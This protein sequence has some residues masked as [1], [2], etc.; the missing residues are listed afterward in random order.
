MVVN[1]YGRAPTLK[2]ERMIYDLWQW[3]SSGWKQQMWRGMSSCHK[4][5][6]S[7][8]VNQE[9]SS[10]METLCFPWSGGRLFKYYQINFMFQIIPGL[11]YLVTGTW[12]RVLG[13]DA[14][15]F[16][17]RF[18]A[19]EVVERQVVLQLL[20]FSPVTIIS[21]ILHTQPHDGRL[22]AGEME[23]TGRHST[24]QDSLWTCNI[25]ARSSNHFCRGNA[26]SFTY[27]C[28]CVCACEFAGALA[29]AFTLVALVIQH[30]K[31]LRR[32][33]LSFEA[34]PAT[35]YS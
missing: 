35:S 20:W 7:S 33:I 25:E 23:S 18:V 31:R 29:C 13:F 32:V 34:C 21:P 6:H 28:V 5:N 19:S 24:R 30:A 4:G 10:R 16:H 1:K 22:T 8:Y 15:L 3:K 2:T 12:M 14:R 9:A 26:I 27:I 17:V 11:W